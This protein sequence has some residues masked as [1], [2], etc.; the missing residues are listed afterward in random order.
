MAASKKK[1]LSDAAIQSKC[2]S[3]AIKYNLNSHTIIKC[4][5]ECWMPTAEK[6]TH[7]WIVSNMRFAKMK[8]SDYI[9]SV[10]SVIFPWIQTQVKTN[11]SRVQYW[12]KKENCRVNDQHIEFWVSKVSE[13]IASSLKLWFHTFPSTLPFCTCRAPCLSLQVAV[14]DTL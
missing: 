13:V 9:P 1:N 5:T 4:W 14:F 12:V 8:K 3:L 10:F 6:K 11:K 7:P 2:L